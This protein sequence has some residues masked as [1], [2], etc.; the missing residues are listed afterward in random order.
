VNE[1]DL[2]GLLQRHAVRH[3]VPGAGIGVV[4][5]GVAVTACYG[6]AD[7]AS[8]EPVTAGV[9][10]SAGSLTKSMVA[11]VIAGLAE[12]G[13]LSLDDKVARHLP[14]LRASGWAERAAVRDLLANRS[15]IPLRS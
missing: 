8:G 14:E 13:R 4:R 5:D 7:A 9:R 1:R 11:T 2:T 10:F 6:V 3:S 15:G 12:A